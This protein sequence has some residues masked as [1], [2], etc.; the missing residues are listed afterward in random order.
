MQVRCHKRMLKEILLLLYM[1]KT[2]KATNK[3]RRGIRLTQKGVGR[4]EQ[5]RDES[6][7]AHRKRGPL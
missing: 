3:A 2:G 6:I 7:G 4:N 1:P 5:N